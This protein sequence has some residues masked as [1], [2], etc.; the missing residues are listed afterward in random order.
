MEDAASALM[1]IE[2]LAV[3]G[4]PH[5]RCYCHGD[6]PTVFIMGRGRQAIEAVQALDLDHVDELSLQH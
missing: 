4:R 5:A 1:T 3:S 2:P 6:D